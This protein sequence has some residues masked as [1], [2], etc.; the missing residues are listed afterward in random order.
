LLNAEPALTRSFFP[1][2]YTCQPL[3]GRRKPT[4][5]PKAPAPIGFT[6]N[7]RYAFAKKG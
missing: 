7:G 6:Y 1:A 3:S 5:G 2:I 4:L